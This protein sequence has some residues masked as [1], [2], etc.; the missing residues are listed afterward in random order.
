MSSVDR[1]MRSAAFVCLNVVLTLLSIAFFSVGGYAMLADN[2]AIGPNSDPTY[3]AL[4]NLT[5][6]GESVS[7]TNLDL[8]RDAGT[9]HLRSGTV[10]FAAPV[11]GHVT[12]AV[13][14]G[15]GNFVLDP[16]LEMEL[17]TYSMDS[18]FDVGA[19]CDVVM[20][21]RVTESNVDEHFRMLVPLY[22]E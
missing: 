12:G 13:F 8:K 16:P 15:E 7:V 19:D 17:P 10:C 11:N 2:A 5:L 4:R 9:F 1:A 18:S 3:Q 14:S 22:L 6:S 20:S 21:L